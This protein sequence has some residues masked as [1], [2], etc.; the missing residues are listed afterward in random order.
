MSRT[1]LKDI[2]EALDAGETSLVEFSTNEID[3][4]LA[5]AIKAESHEIKK[6]DKIDAKAFEREL[7]QLSTAGADR[8]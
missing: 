5:A 3:H 4:G 7:K 6:L 8:S 2:S 1:G